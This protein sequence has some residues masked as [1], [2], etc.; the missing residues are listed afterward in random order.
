MVACWPGLATVISQDTD[1]FPTFPVSLSFHFNEKNA[2]KKIKQRTAKKV[3]PE[4]QETRETT[5]AA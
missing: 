4:I 2:L 5:T 1:Y 3:L